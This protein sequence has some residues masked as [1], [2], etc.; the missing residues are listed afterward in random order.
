MKYTE[1]LKVFGGDEIKLRNVIQATRQQMYHF[2]SRLKGG[3]DLELSKYRNLLI[4][5]YMAERDGR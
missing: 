1:A 5:I 2:R 3:T 4:D